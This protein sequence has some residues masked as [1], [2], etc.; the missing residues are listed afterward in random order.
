MD[1]SSE[2]LSDTGNNARPSRLGPTLVQVL[3]ATIGATAL[4]AFSIFIFT[5]PWELLV[6][7]TDT[8]AVLVFDLCLSL[9]FFVQHSGM[10]RRS[11]KAWL[12][13]LLP[14]CYHG[15]LYSI[16]SGITLFCVVFLWQ[17][18]AP[19]LLSADGAARI[20]MRVLFLTTLGVIAWSHLAL[21]SVDSFGLRAIGNHLRGKSQP[22]ATFIEQGP[23]RWIRHPQYACILVMLWSYP[24]LTADRLLLNLLWSIWV[25]IGTRLEER[26]LAITIGDQYREYQSRV[27]MLIPSLAKKRSR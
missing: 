16:A 2:R 14:A 10:V 8:R 25:V 5:G 11:F 15:A 21:H 3:S 13:R 23:Y 7:Y 18:S 22:T 20:A 4:L 19:A 1:H 17:A 9:L 12:E 26:D 24:D 6:F 27:P